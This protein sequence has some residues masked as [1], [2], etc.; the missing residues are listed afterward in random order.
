[1][2]SGAARPRVESYATDPALPLR[3][4]VV[5]A[6]Q[7]TLRLLRQGLVQPYLQPALS[8]ANLPTR[9]FAQYRA[10]FRLLRVEAEWHAGHGRW[11]DAVK[12]A[13]DIAALGG[14][15]EHGGGTIC[16]MVGA[17]GYHMAA[18]DL[19]RMLPYLDR[20]ALAAALRRWP[21]AVAEQPPMSEVAAAELDIAAGFF[22]VAF[23]EPDWRE[24]LSW[25]VDEGYTK[26]QVAAITPSRNAAAMAAY[27]ARLLP[28]VDAPFGSVPIPEPPEDVF[29][30]YLAQ[31]IPAHWAIGQLELASQQVMLAELV[32]EAYRRDHDTLPPDLASLVPHYLATAPRDP[33]TG[34]SLVY[35]VTGDGYR[36]YSVGPNR[37][38][39]GG[40]KFVWPNER[41]AAAGYL[42]AAGDVW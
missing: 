18:A 15:I 19:R 22:A 30:A 17:A 35:R 21:A 5:A 26:E 39:D 6:N 42:T 41:T 29:A 23:A 24:G 37:Q 32:I 28:V 10:L 33:F 12:S 11:S 40:L 31:T 3:D 9:W 34:R 36:V 1:M 25:L 8:P 16:Q 14:K 4:V 38:D 13:C 2:V 7:E 27:R 20:G